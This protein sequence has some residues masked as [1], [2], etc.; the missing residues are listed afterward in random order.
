MHKEF[1]KYDMSVNDPQMCGQREEATEVYRDDVLSPA[2]ERNRGV[3]TVKK[4]EGT[5]LSFAK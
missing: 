2:R 4:R 1:K 3:G 5:E